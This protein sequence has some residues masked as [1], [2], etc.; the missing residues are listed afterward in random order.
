MWKKINYIMPKYIVFSVFFLINP[1]N[2]LQ[3]GI[4]YFGKLS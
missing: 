1:L 3:I 2:V 4:F